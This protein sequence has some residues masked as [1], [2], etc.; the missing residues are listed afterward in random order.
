VV[1]KIRTGNDTG[2]GTSTLHPTLLLLDS[3]GVTPIPDTLVNPVPCS[4]P[5]VCGSTCPL[6]RRRLPYTRT[7]YLAVRAVAPDAC[8]GG[9]Y[10]MVVISPGGTVPVLVADDAN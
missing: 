8:S 7:Y 4:T 6:F 1:V 10:R 2:T 9:K 5:N 3:D